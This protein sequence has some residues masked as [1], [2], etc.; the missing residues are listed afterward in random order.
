[1][2]IIP[3]PHISVVIP[4]LNSEKTIGECLRSILDENYPKDKV[5]IIIADGGSVDNTLEIIKGLKAPNIRVIPNELKTGE[6]GKAVGAKMAKGEII[7][8]IDSDNILPDQNWFKKMI[9]PFSDQDIIASEPIGYTYRREDGYITRYCALMGM[10]DPLCLFIGNYDRYNYITGK[11]TD[12]PCQ[13]EKKEGYLKVGL[14][15]RYLP[16]IGANGFLIRAD[17]LSKYHIG[18]YLFDIDVLCE[19]LDI[20]CKFKI[21]KVNTDIIHIFCGDFVDFLRKQRRRIRD[22]AYYKKLRLRKYKWGGL[23]MWGLAKF[24]LYNILL[25]PL[26]LQVIE[27]YSKKRDKAWLF[28]IPACLAT[29]FIYAFAGVSNIFVSKP[30]KRDKWQTRG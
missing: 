19:L 28:H 6:A 10:N 27:G 23:R 20:G 4:S 14:D 5:E 3:Y 13:T 16:T 9:E 26:I 25:F 8:F 2:T 17:V 1:M 21:A 29:F 22:Y 24:C 15:K 12:M 7:A 18:E 11:W 30:L